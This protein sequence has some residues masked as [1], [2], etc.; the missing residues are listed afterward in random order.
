MYDISRPRIWSCM[1]WCIFL[2]SHWPD[3][4]MSFRLKKKRKLLSIRC[5]SFFKSK[6]R[7]AL[8]MCF[9]KFSKAYRASSR[10]HWKIGVSRMHK[11]LKA[12]KNSSKHKHK[13][14]TV[15]RLNAEDVPCCCRGTP[16]RSITFVSLLFKSFRELSIFNFSIKSSELLIALQSTNTMWHCVL[17][18]QDSVTVAL[19]WHNAMCWCRCSVEP[20]LRGQGAFKFTCIPLKNL[21]S[22]CY[23]DEAQSFRRFSKAHDLYMMWHV[24]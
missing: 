12:F 4:E 6:Y 19:S 24:I 1:P 2:R 17:G 8:W 21:L 5:L 18:W 3:L 13:C 15:F 16:K 9:T 14:D 10:F 22:Y 7:I 11:K 23:S 20:S